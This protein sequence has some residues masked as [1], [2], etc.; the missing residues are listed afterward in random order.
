MAML[1]ELVEILQP[2]G[3]NTDL[4]QGDSYLTIG[5]VVSSIVGLHR[6]LDTLSSNVKYQTALVNALLSSLCDRFSG[7]LQNVKI[8]PTK[9]E[10][11]DR[12]KKILPTKSESRTQIFLHHFTI[13]GMIWPQ[14]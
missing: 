2:F 3:E 4:L 10:S 14:P 8:L 5:C 13:Y 1:R 6:C 7:L 11:R 12:I 9:S